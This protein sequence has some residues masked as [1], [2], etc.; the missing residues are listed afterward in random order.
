M[1]VVPLR[2]RERSFGVLA[3]ADREVRGGLAPFSSQDVETLTLLAAQGGLAFSAIVAHRQRVA[4]E[5]LERELALAAAVQQHLLPRLPDFLL[6]WQLAGFSMPSRHVG[7]DLFDFFPAG[8]EAL[9]ALFDV[10][11]KG[12]PA[13]LLAASLQGA[14]RVAAQQASSL[15]E[16]AK[17]LDGHLATLWAAHQF[18]TAFFFKLRADGAASYL[19][20]G[21]MPAIVVGT[22][23]ETRLLYAQGPP[24]GLVPNPWF[25]EDTLVLQP[26]ETMVVATDGIV[27]ATD[28][29]GEEFGLARLR[30]L[31]AQNPDVSPG[32]LARN[33]L[34]AVRE[35]ARGEPVSDDFT[36]VA[37][38]R[39]V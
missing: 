18:A 12:V 26:G 15:R 32:E 30:T 20:A 29:H 24:L 19:G 8:N 9:L 13:A 39:T 17:T 36:F 21:H 38:R 4:Q 31:V 37:V 16:L 2:G 6:G 14:L 27:E 10:S 35:F 28:P 7:G 25:E 22:C 11:G 3:V 1:V 34:D 23:G 33:V 5:R